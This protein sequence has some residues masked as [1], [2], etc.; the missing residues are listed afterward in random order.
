MLKLYVRTGCPFCARVLAK[1]GELGLPFEERNIADERIL[2]ELLAL[3]GKR[4]VPFL[5]DESRGVSL[6]ESED[7]VRHLE[8]AYGS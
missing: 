2:D 1:L 8:R 6:Y 3:G 7:I 5:V 4:Q